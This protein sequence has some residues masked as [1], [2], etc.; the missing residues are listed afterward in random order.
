MCDRRCVQDV[1]Q[2]RKVHRMQSSQTNLTVVGITLVAKAFLGCCHQVVTST[3]KIESVQ[4]RSIVAHYNTRTLHAACLFVLT[5][6]G[7]K[8]QTK[9]H[10][11]DSAVG[12]IV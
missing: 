1:M 6:D 4:L 2:R 8:A 9:N 10:D 3:K 11:V 5:Y 12:L 7:N